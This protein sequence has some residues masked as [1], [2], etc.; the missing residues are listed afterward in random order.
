MRTT[1]RSLIAKYPFAS[2]R[3]YFSFFYSHSSGYEK[4]KELRLDNQA[5]IFIYL[6]NS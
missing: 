6:P 5:A 3:A 2:L 4:K 1:N